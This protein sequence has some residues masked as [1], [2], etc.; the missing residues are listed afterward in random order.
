MNEGDIRS[1]A[2]SSG[3]SNDKA[4]AGAPV[5]S[6]YALQPNG[7]ELDLSHLH[8]DI[9]VR[10]SGAPRASVCCP[11]PPPSLAL[12]SICF[13]VMPSMQPHEF[14]VQDELRAR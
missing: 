14:Y 1:R 3:F 9:E 4:P 10:L 2:F 11:P 12:F 13:F 5:Y 8:L 6:A 7:Q